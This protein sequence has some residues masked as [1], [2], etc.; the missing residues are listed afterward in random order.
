MRPAGLFVVV[1]AAPHDIGITESHASERLVSTVGKA[2]VTRQRTQGTK[3]PGLRRKAGCAITNSRTA[4]ANSGRP[5]AP[6]APK[7]IAPSI[8]TT[9]TSGLRCF[10]ASTFATRG[11]ALPTTASKGIESA[12]SSFGEAWVAIAPRIAPARARGSL[13]ARARRDCAS[14][15]SFVGRSPFSYPIVVASNG[16]RPFPCSSDSAVSISRRSNSAVHAPAPPNVAV[17]TRSG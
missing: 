12:R 13:D 5:C 3:R 9:F 6:A 10:R 1:A 4:A 2:V 8:S 15:S 7:C 11:S 14:S 16:R 17:T